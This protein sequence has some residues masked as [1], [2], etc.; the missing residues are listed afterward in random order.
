MKKFINRKDRIKFETVLND[1]IFRVNWRRGVSEEL[2]LCWWCNLQSREKMRL[3]ARLWTFKTAQ[4]YERRR[5]V[6]IFYIFYNM[7]FLFVCQKLNFSLSMINNHIISTVK[8]CPYFAVL[9]LR[10]IIIN[11][12]ILSI[13]LNNFFFHSFTL[14]LSFLH[15][16]RLL[17]EMNRNSYLFFFFPPFVTLRNCHAKRWF[18]FHS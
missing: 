9:S 17:C 15:L 5:F 18:T 7:I 2:P 1:L 4:M 13:Y 11:I 12:I 8:N 16:L 6:T 10:T 14:Y 3:S